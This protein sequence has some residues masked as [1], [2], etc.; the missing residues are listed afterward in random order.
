MQLYKDNDIQLVNANIDKIIEQIEEIKTKIFSKDNENIN[1]TTSDTNTDTENINETTNSDAKTENISKPEQKVVVKPGPSREIIDKIV[2]IT[3]NFVKSKKRKIYGGYAQNKTIS[4]KN[5]DD[6]FY[7]DEDIPD[8]DVYSPEPLI[9]IKELCDVLYNEGY[10]DV[11]GKEA[12][13]KETYK[14][15]TNGYNAIDLSY[16]PKNIYNNIPFIEIENIRYVHPAFSIIDLYKMMTEPLFSSFRWK[17]IFPRLYLLQKHY[18]F[19]KLLK[20]PYNPNIGT[21]NKRALTIVFDFIKDNK[22]V[23]LFGEIAYNIFL[24]SLKNYKDFNKKELLIPYY[25]FV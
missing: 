25:S 9:D 4:Y 21:L 14:I 12:M 22:N 1:E 24:R 19:N 18:P 2:D 10:T 7:S 6:A 13:H 20:Q 15:F 3:L 23:Y 17:K 11:V 16:V 8:I 5:S